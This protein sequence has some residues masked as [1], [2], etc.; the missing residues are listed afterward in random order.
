MAPRGPSSVRLAD[1]TTFH[2]G[3]NARRFVSATSEDELISTVAECDAAGEPVLVLGGGSNVLVP[4]EGFDGTVVHVG[5]RGVTAE[6]SSCGGAM[7]RVQAGENWDEF[8]AFAV[9]RGWVGVETLSGIPGSVGATPI[10]NV[11]AYGADVSQSVSSVRTWDRELGQ[12]KTH[13][14]VDCGFGYRTSLFKRTPGRHLVLDV[15][16]QFPLGTLSA[17]IAYPELAHALGVDV[18][19]RSPTTRV[20]DAV[21]AIRR[22]KGMVLDESDHDTWSGGSFF[23]NPLLTTEAAALLPP[24]APRFPAGDR[25]KTSAAW[26]IQHAGFVKGHGTTRAALSGKHVLALTNRGDASAEDLLALAR[27][28]RD[29]VRA[30]FGIT[31]E[32]EV[33]ILGRSL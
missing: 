6:V 27:E 18:G 11:G 8:V 33:N 26:L 19:E 25:V 22:S 5:T 4:D 9:A 28:V 20:R 32:A 10:Q 12:V 3:G 31:L 14:A 7:V 21:L 13:P 15:S 1:H 17:P 2:V 23:T 16:F 24:G 29:G 30:T